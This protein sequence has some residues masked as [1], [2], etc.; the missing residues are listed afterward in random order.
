MLYEFNEWK[1]AH[2]KMAL[3]CS[4]H[5]TACHTLLQATNPQRREGLRCR[6]VA[7]SVLDRREH[8]ER[9]HGPVQRLKDALYRDSNDSLSKD[10]V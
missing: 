2:F 6:T 4:Y 5:H 10:I 3:R 8:A 1:S 7:S 9:P